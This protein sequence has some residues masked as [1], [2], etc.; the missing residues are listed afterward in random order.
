MFSLRHFKTFIHLKGDV[1]L[2]CLTTGGAG[3]YSPVHQTVKRQNQ[4]SEQPGR[5][6]RGNQIHQL[7]SP[8]INKYATPKTNNESV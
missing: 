4:A 8:L 7:V 1:P 2:P 5:R 3:G 6:A